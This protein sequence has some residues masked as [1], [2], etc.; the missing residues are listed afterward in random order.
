MNNSI[1]LYWSIHF[2][3]V[4]NFVPFSIFFKHA[5]ITTKNRANIINELLNYDTILK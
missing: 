1:Y 3:I 2:N 4:F 5:L